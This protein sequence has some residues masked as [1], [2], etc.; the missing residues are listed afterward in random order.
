MKINLFIVEKS[1]HQFEILKRKFI[2]I[3]Q[4]IGVNERGMYDATINEFNLSLIR[5]ECH[6]FGI[7]MSSFVFHS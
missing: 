1:L 2:F 6:S 4:S 3:N 5:N 7:C